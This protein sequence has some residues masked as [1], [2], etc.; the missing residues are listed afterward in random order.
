MRIVKAFI[1]SA[2]A[3]AGLAAPVMASVAASGAVPQAS[4]TANGPAYF[5][6]A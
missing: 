5:Y 4:A 6:H 2:F 3:V 1:A